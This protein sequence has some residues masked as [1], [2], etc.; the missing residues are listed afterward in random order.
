VKKV[1]DF[2][3]PLKV[4][5]FFLIVELFI[6][7]QERFCSIELVIYKFQHVDCV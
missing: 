6:A 3:V 2:W 4:K 1:I 7:S 5:S